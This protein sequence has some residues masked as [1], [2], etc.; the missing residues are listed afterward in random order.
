[1]DLTQEQIEKLASS[2]SKIGLNNEKLWDDIKNIIKYIDLLN[3]VNT[4]WIKST[5]SVVEKY[6]ELRE[7]KLKDKKISRK[8][9][10][11]CS[12]QKVIQDQIAIS[13]IM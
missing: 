3:E 4:T 12:K 8:D 9:L 1:M 10:L 5:I 7:D 11:E 2:L 13:N 6:N